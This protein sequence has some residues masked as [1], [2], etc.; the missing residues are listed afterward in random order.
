MSNEKPKLT[1]KSELLDEAER[2]LN[3]VDTTNENNRLNSIA[4]LQAAARLVIKL[5]RSKYGL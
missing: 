3:S 1:Y 5:L 4:E 2:H